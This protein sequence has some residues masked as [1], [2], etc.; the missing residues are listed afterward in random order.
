MVIKLKI[1][2]G[3]ESDN[4]FNL[5]K[6]LKVTLDAFHKMNVKTVIIV[7]SFGGWV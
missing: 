2:L 4:V 1:Y 3:K 5:Y 7:D 6:K